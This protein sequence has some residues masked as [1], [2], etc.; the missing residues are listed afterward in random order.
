MEIVYYSKGT[1]NRFETQKLMENII[2]NHMRD[3]DAVFAF[4]DEDGLGVLQ[5]LKMANMKPGKDVD[6]V[7]I[8]G[9]QDAIKAVIADE[10]LATIKRSPQM[11]SLALRC[12][13]DKEKGHKEVKNVLVPYEVI[14]KSNAYEVINQSY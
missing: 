2:I 9:I 14:T 4:G 7:S 8:G 10:Y 5:A 12:I 6:I 13:K 11:G 1:S 3:F